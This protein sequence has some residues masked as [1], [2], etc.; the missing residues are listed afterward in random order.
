MQGF[1]PRDT[2]F[3][4]KNSILV[5]SP[6]NQ[7]CEQ[8]RSNLEE[9][10]RYSVQA[11][12]SSHEAIR[13]ANRKYFDLAILDAEL[14]DLPLLQ[15]TH[16]LLE[17]Q[18]A[19]KILLYP[20]ENNPQHPA[21]L[22]LSVNGYL[23]KPFFA[24]EL[25]Q[26]LKDL[27]R[28][29]LGLQSLIS[30][31]EVEP[32]NVWLQNPDQIKILMEQL[33]AQTSAYS[34]LICVKG[35]A[36]L[37]V[38]KISPQVTQ[39]VTSFLNHYWVN[40]ENQEIF[41]YMRM[42][43]DTSVVLIYSLPINGGASVTLL[44]P[45]AIQIK[46]VRSE[47]RQLRDAYLQQ[48]M[49]M[50]EYAAPI[51]PSFAAE[52]R[53]ERAET[54]PEILEGETGEEEI[55]SLSDI[56]GENELRNINQLLSD[57]PI[58]D[59]DSAAAE[60]VQNHW[61]SIEQPPMPADEPTVEPSAA[62]TM[63]FAPS[64]RESQPAELDRETTE[65]L[66]QGQPGADEFTLANEDQAA[67]METIEMEQSIDADTSLAEES[68]PTEETS[69]PW[70]APAQ[71]AETVELQSASAETIDEAAGKTFSIKPD[72]V[73]AQ[74]AEPSLQE[75]IDSAVSFP[76]DAASQPGDTGTIESRPIAGEEPSVAETQPMIAAPEET[77]P[78]QRDFRFTYHCLIVPQDEKT[79]LVR[80][81]AERLGY[82]LPQ[83][84]LI[85]GWKLKS[86]TIRPQYLLWSVSLP[87]ECTPRDVVEK[88]KSQ[89]YSHI[90][91]NFPEILLH[92]ENADFWADGYLVLSGEE[93]PARSLI[94]DFQKS[95]RQNHE[96]KPVQE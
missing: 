95:S 34:G 35:Q 41:R 42:D 75:L 56:L 5:A 87:L 26:Y 65:G 51:D 63:L 92:N 16:E 10:G 78:A 67:S 61:Q 62:D 23:K 69:L 32:A 83:V 76:W 4:V 20:P 19:L 77:L 2:L 44:Y 9:G 71:T 50:Q 53:I 80:D 55:L 14:T 74:K 64:E 38:G 52:Q 60:E 12:G 89:T 79:Y 93:P 46:Q 28:P 30:E 8:I 13:F 24:P 43:A 73:E 36:I 22:G 70:D 31:P 33:L 72:T 81:L 59:P 39:N 47:A 29:E 1:S 86:L 94:I 91:T 66:L 54:D 37:E 18:P 15:L 17:L 40:Y 82:L 85:N 21:I 27:L 84:H 49:N 57:L 3:N 88:V 11:A 48:R 96:I 68:I 45:P 90:Q 58:P 7:I 6:D 25:S